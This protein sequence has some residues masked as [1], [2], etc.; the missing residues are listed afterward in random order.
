MV[1]DLS[2]NVVIGQGVTAQHTARFLL[3][4]SKKVKIFSLKDN[5]LPQELSHLYT[6]SFV[7]STQ[8]WMSPG[9]SPE[10]PVLELLRKDNIILDVDYF[11]AHTEVPAIL[12]TGTNGKSSVCLYL[13]S[14]LKKMGKNSVCVGNFQPGILSLETQDLDWVI[15]ELSSYQ[16]YWLQKNHHVA[17]TVLLNVEHDHIDWHGSF[18]AYT[19]LKQGVHQYGQVCVDSGDYGGMSFMPLAHKLFHRGHAWHDAMNMAAA[20]LVLKSL[21]MEVAIPEQWPGLP[22]RQSIGYQPLSIV[23]NDSK[24]TNIAATLSAVAMMKMRYPNQSKVL[25]LAGVSKVTNHSQLRESVRGCQLLIV[26]NDFQDLEDI[27]QRFS[28]LED[29]IKTLALFKGVILFS[30]AGAS[31]DAYSHF[32]ARG[33]DFDRCIQR[34]CGTVT[35]D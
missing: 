30:P 23:I 10:D 24:A 18:S 8:V 17:A 1:Y 15:I 28:N 34:Y 20:Q 27:G 33:E 32:E 14:L 5:H 21:G 26:G 11:L 29:A 25:I 16:L 7:P 22:Y 35:S 2:S 13:Q 9:I 6:N 31:Y 19:S 12:V 3:S 4:K